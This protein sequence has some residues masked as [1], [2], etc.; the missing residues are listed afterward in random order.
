MENYT[1]ILDSP[2]KIKTN[3][4]LSYLDAIKQQAEETRE[5][6]LLY[7]GDSLEDK[8][9]KLEV[10]SLQFNNPYLTGLITPLFIEIFEKGGYNYY[11]PM[12]IYC[13]LSIKDKYRKDNIHT[14]HNDIND[15]L[16]DVSIFKVLG[17]INPDWDPQWGG[18]F[19]WNNKT[20]SIG[21]N[22]FLIFDPKIPHAASDIFC[23]KK[24]LAIDFTVYAKT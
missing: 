5:W 21:V 19:I 17:I 20:Y 6:H 10:L 15:D 22:E 1:P 16:K 11:S 2:V 4:S 3:L 8:H 12:F 7:G 23:D 24:R 18:G 9:L 13:G 14:D